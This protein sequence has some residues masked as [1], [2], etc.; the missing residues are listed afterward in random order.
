MV[1]GAAARRRT[2]GTADSRS[3][4]AAG[5]CAPAP[6]HSSVGLAPPG[7]QLAAALSE[8]CLTFAGL[9][10][11][12]PPARD[13]TAQPLA[14]SGGA[15]AGAAPGRSP[16]SP[17]WPGGILTPG[18]GGGGRRRT[19]ATSPW[20]LPRGPVDRV[21]DRL[22]PDQATTVWAARGGGRPRLPGP[23]PWPWRC[24][25]SRRRAAGGCTSGSTKRSASFTALG[26]AKAKSPASCWAAA[27]RARRRP[28]FT[29]WSSR[30]TSLARRCSASSP[31]GPPCSPYS[32]P[33][34]DHRPGQALRGS[35]LLGRRVRRAAGRVRRGRAT[36][37]RWPAR[38]GRTRPAPPAR[39]Q[40]R[41]TRNLPFRDPPVPGQVRRLSGD[42]RRPR[43]ADTGGPW[44]RIGGARRRR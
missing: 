33:A 41:C 5:L 10:T 28:T 38:P 3:L 4:R 44:T 25:T 1:T 19:R 40:G 11:M 18:R 20:A 24:T 9:A 26:L 42:P 35:E 22:R 13:V 21:R 7:G 29:W 32:A 27:C 30:L 2:G 36:G 37:G 43:R 16:T 31:T 12:S 14:E 8:I 39:S 15:V 6:S 23:R 17:S 34:T